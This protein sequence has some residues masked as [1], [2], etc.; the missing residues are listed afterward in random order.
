MPAERSEK[1]IDQ[2][3]ILVGLAGTE[4]MPI[5]KNGVAYRITAESL[6][7]NASQAITVTQDT[8]GLYINEINA[9]VLPNETWTGGNY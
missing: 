2:L 4:S 3:D 7:A 8:D 5:E 6:L 9:T 1:T